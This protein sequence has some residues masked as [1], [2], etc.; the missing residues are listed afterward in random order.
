MVFL[1]AA[2]QDA[3]SQPKQQT[4]K[5]AVVVTGTYVALPLD[6]MDRTV[7]VIDV[8]RD[9]SLVSSVSDYLQTDSSVNL[10]RRGPNDIQTDI[11]LR[12]GS[13]GQA[14]VLLN[15]MRLNDPQTAHHNMDLP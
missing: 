10:Q 5:F 3:N 7:Q 13:F 15:G 12:G 14:L 4:Q 8:N 9:R 6:E 1:S 11:S 2:A